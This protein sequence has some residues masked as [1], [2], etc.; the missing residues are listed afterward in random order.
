MQTYTHFDTVESAVR[1]AHRLRARPM[2]AA[3][4][5][6]LLWSYTARLTI[7]N[8]PDSQQVLRTL[9]Y[10]LAKRQKHA[11]A[12]KEKRDRKYLQLQANLRKGNSHR[13]TNNCDH[14][15]PL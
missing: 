7:A 11:L 9:K 4:S 2:L 3:G 13:R 1:S 10:A 12:K 6:L 15:F 5:V 14:K 8:L